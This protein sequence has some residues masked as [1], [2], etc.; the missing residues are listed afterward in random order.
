MSSS[1]MVGDV[2]YY[3]VCSHCEKTFRVDVGH[4]CPG[5]K[6]VR[7]GD[8]YI[9]QR[10]QG[11]RWYRCLASGMRI[12]C[13]ARDSFC[14]SR[15]ALVSLDQDGTLVM[16][17]RPDVYLAI[18]TE[19]YIEEKKL[20]DRQGPKL[21]TVRADVIIE[22]MTGILAP[23]QWREEIRRRKCTSIHVNILSFPPPAPELPEFAR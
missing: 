10:W 3:D 9:D 21:S 4:Y 19:I 15:E 7:R 6:A 2:G 1:I 12:V 13:D 18:R 14:T 20:V 17:F 22:R 5:A 8:T 11:D 23:L 16:C